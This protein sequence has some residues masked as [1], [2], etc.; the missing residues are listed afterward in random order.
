MNPKLLL[1]LGTLAAL[2]I[3][4]LPAIALA[5]DDLPDEY[6]AGQVVV[7]LE[8]GVSIE[9]I[10]ADYGTSIL[11]AVES[12]G[13]YLLQIP[14]GADEETFEELLD[15]DERVDEADL[16]FESGVPGGSTQSFFFNVPMSDF[17]TQYAWD[18]VNLAAAQDISTG[19]GVIVALIDTGIDGAHPALAGIVRP[20]GFNFMDGNSDV[21]DVGNGADD[22]SD[23]YIDE[24]VGHGTFTAGI[25][26]YMAPDAELLPIKVLNSDGTASTFHVVQGIYYAIDHGA[27]IINLSLGTSSNSELIAM[28][29]QD[30]VDVGVLVL[31]AGGNANQIDPVVFPAA[32]PN[33]LGVAATDQLDV[34]AEFSNFGSHM[35]LSAPG[36]EIVSIYPDNQYSRCS[37]TSASTAMVSGAAALLKAAHPN[38][39]LDQ[40]RAFLAAAADD[41]DATN[42][43]YAGL[44]GAGRLNIGAALDVCSAD[45]DNSGGVNVDDL[46]A[47]I[48]T[49]GDC[50]GCSTDIAPSPSGNGVVNVDDLLAVING[51]GP[52][53]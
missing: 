9:E 7:E 38:A 16:N 53:Q 28:A 2:S 45:I 37:G 13:I 31:A 49:W 39:T 11:L 1:A 6:A 18:K 48:N 46:L 29:I 32:D 36:F 24:L 3:A 8:R 14:A 47:V 4:L 19:H 44:L 12:Q 35:D 40:L 20:D 30:A 10:N 5:G 23:G 50:S 52:C 25:I 34:K 51:W 27:T 21:A 33:V 15:R 22:D 43:K 42:P 17:S 26:A 41:L